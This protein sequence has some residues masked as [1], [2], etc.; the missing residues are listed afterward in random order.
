MLHN[1]YEVEKALESFFDIQTKDQD[2][3]WEITIGEK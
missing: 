2:S 1:K 3:E